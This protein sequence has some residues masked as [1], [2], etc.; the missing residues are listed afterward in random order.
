M[1]QTLGWGSALDWSE[2]AL[3]NA[4]GHATI[5]VRTLPQAGVVGVSHSIEMRK[6]L[7]PS[8]YA[9]GAPHVTLPLAWQV[10]TFQCSGCLM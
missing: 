3:R 1:S 7:L 8:G 9:D 6:L 10:G 4:V 2:A 5:R